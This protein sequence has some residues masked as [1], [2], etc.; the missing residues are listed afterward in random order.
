[1]SGPKAESSSGDKDEEMSPAEEENE[2]KDSME[3]AS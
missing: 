1:M 3:D 2:E